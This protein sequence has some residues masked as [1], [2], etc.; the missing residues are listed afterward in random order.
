MRAALATLVAV[1]TAAV[2][3]AAAHADTTDL[4]TLTQGSLTATW[5]LPATNTIT[6]PFEPLLILGFMPLSESINGVSVIPQEIYI[7]DG[8]NLSGS[9]G[10]IGTGYMPH[11]LQIVASSPFYDMSTG[12]EMAT[13]NTQFLNGTFTGLT[14]TGLGAFTPFTLTIGPEAPATTPTPEPSSLLLLATAA[15]GAIATLKRRSIL[16]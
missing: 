9:F 7:H 11:I 14:Q 13:Y 8:F 5:T 1:A 2:L 3:P 15:L 4:F 16:G 12:Q 10:T 6:Q